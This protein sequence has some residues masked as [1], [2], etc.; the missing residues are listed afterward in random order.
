MINLIDEDDNGSFDNS[1]VENDIP[2]EEEELIPVGQ[3][4]NMRNNASP[5]HRYQDDSPVHNYM[6]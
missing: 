3:H 6:Q 5:Q 2:D 4:S 1:Q